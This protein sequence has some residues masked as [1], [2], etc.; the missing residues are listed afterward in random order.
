MKWRGEVAVERSEFE[1]L[2]RERGNPDGRIQSGRSSRIEPNAFENWTIPQHRG[3]GASGPKGTIHKSPARSAGLVQM[4][5][6][7]LQGR[8]MRGNAVGIFADP[9]PLPGRP[10]MKRPDRTPDGGPDHPAL[11]AGLL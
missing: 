2:D 3:S 11:R 1:I 10:R 4:P 5:S 8:I 9:I 7:V 6:A